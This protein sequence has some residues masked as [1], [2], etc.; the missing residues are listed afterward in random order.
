M[1]FSWMYLYIVIQIKKYTYF[2][3][4]LNQLLDTSGDPKVEKQGQGKGG[5]INWTGKTKLL[6]GLKQLPL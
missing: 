6:A 3:N 2:I 4:I 5:I 1:D